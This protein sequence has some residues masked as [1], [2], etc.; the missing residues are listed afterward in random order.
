[1]QRDECGLAIGVCAGLYK[2]KM[3]AALTSSHFLLSL[4][5]F[6]GGQVTTCKHGMICAFV[7]IP[8]EHWKHVKL[9]EVKKPVAKATKAA[10]A[11]RSRRHTTGRQLGRACPFISRE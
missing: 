4:T 6:S 2:P 1:M 11:R 5:V 9:A 3:V 10:G 8:L 7:F